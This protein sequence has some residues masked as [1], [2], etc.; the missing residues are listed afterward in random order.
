M[1]IILVQILKA[2]RITSEVGLSPSATT[3]LSQT[4]P[5]LWFCKQSFT[6]TQL[7]PFAYGL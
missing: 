1:K 2:A 5:P 7:H 3:E 6:E 4:L